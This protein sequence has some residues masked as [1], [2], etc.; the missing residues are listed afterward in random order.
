[1]KQSAITSLTDTI[2][3]DNI[4]F[5]EPMNQHTTFKVGGNAAC[6]VT[7]GDEAQLIQTIQILREND[8]PYYV[9]GNG[10]NLLI[11]DSGYDGCIVQICRNMGTVTIQDNCLTA[12]AGALLSQV[13]NA[14]YKKG[15]TG[16]EF[17]SG[18]PGTIG[19]A[20]V[21]NAGAYG[22]EMKQIV[23][24]VRVLAHDGHILELSCDEMEFGYRSSIVRKM[25]YTVLSVAIRL[26]YGNPTEIK[27]KM[28]ELKGQ[29]IAKQPLE[30]PSAGSTFKR[31]QG[32]FAGKLIEEAGLRGYTIGGAQVSEKHCGFVINRG[33]ATADD[34]FCLITH[35]RDR[36]LQTSGVTLE[37]EV[38]MLGEFGRTCVH[39]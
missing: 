4:L 13:A 8:E 18:I 27:S 34:I 32:Y 28:D 35:I 6:F 21:M 3:R 24:S 1:M 25:S 23:E 12:M 10:S 26:T 14:A 31:P 22:G 33:N 29:R 9:L 39:S 2:G 19:G 15:L 36:V 30:F 37:P 20:M 38:C 7:P 16:F 17:A 5:H 11:S